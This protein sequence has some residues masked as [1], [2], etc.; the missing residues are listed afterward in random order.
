MKQNLTISFIFILIL[1][2]AAFGQNAPTAS[3]YFERATALYNEGKYEQALT[4]LRQAEK[5]ESARFD[6]QSNIG[7]ALFILQRFGESS[8]AFL[9]AIKINPQEASAHFNLCRSMA[10]EK[11]T[12][13]AIPICQEAMRLNANREEYYVLLAD[14]QRANNQTEESFRILL[15]AA[16]KFE[17]SVTVAGNLGDL[18]YQDGDLAR[19][20]GSMRRRVGHGPARLL[21]DLCVGVR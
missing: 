20:H 21:P 12:S 15:S 19:A 18:Y 1:T 3:E 2:A 8:A 17:S 4:A 14:I 11:K 10:A 6:I 9:K 5:L 16:E 13:L 7:T